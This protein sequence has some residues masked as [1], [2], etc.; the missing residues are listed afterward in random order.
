V[1]GSSR[2]RWWRTL[3]RLVAELHRV[4]A[5]VC[6]A[7]AEQF[8]MGASLDD[9]PAVDYENLVGMDDRGKTVGDHEDRATGKQ[10]IYGFLD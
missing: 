1:S 3:D 10:T 6:A 4:K 8:L 5:E 9:A 2:C 7:L